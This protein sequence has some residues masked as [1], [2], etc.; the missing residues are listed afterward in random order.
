MLANLA[1]S[2]AMTLVVVLVHLTGL[3]LL[4]HFLRSNAY[5]VA[6]KDGTLLRQGAVI[7]G[8][9]LGIFVLHGIEIWLYALAYLAIG[10]FKDFSTALYFSTSSFST[11]GYGDVVLGPDWRIFGAIEAVTG[12]ILIGWSSAFLL[13]VTSRLRVLEHDWESRG[14]RKRKQ[15]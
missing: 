13:S 14:T 6:G 11:L 8:V 12:L 15:K 10:V 1:L 4:L 5:R 9:T 2:V 7:L 3:F